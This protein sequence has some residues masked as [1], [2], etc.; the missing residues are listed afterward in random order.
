MVVDF[1]FWQPAARDCYKQLI[2]DAG[3]SCRLI[4]LKTDQ[5]LPRRR[6]QDRCRCFDAN[7]AFPI[8]DELLASYAAG[9][10]A[11]Y[12]EGRKSSTDPSQDDATAPVAGE[13]SGCD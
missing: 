2:E 10:E 6:L 1:S 3:G 13:W 7:V 9:F 8:T 5:L 12:D 11:R 4:Y